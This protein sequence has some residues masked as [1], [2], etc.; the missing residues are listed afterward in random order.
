MEL[1]LV[2]DAAKEK[3]DIHDKLWFKMCDAVRL[4]LDTF[5]MLTTDCVPYIYYTKKEPS[6]KGVL[7]YT[8]SAYAMYAAAG[9]IADEQDDHW[10]TRKHDW[11]VCLS[12]RQRSKRGT[13]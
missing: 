9:L 3:A 7:K 8:M 1:T 13:E 4:G 12:D 2:L 11:D 6:S 10:W 5:Y